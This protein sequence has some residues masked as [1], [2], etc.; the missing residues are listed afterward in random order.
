[1]GRLALRAGW[2]RDDLQFVHVNEVAGGAETA[3]HLLVF[4]S[5]HGRWSEEVHHTDTE[6]HIGTRRLTYSALPKPGQVPW[7]LA[8]PVL[9]GMSDRL[10]ARA[11]RRALCGASTTT[12]VFVM[13]WMVVMTP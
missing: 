1:M 11:R 5:V 6:L 8:E 13:S 12:C 3:A 10:L 7:A 4:D 9:V 2:S